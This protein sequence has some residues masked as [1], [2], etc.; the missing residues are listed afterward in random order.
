MIAAAF[1]DASDRY[2]GR[3]AIVDGDRRITYA[4]L[5][6]AA[7]HFRDRLRNEANIGRGD[8]VASLLDNSWQFAAAFFAASSLGAIFVPWNPQW[9]D[10]ES[11]E[12]AGRL[13]LH[14]MILDRGKP[15][16]W[17]P[18]GGH[19][20]S[21]PSEFSKSAVLDCEP[22]SGD[23]TA[24]YL[25]TSGSTG[26]PK[27]VPRSCRNLVDGAANVTSAL[28]MQPGKRL[29]SVV[30]FHHSNG[31]HNCLIAPLLHG[32]T[33]IMQRG[34]TPQGCAALIRK[35]AAN[36][37]IGSPFLF[38]LL[39]DRVS[40]PA[41]M[42]SLDLCISAGARMPEPTVERWLRKT[43]KRI[44]QLYGSTET[45]VITI[46]CDDGAPSHP[47]A[48]V[49]VGKAIPGVEIRLVDGEITVRSPAVMSGYFGEKNEENFHEGFYRTGDSGYVTADGGVYL[50]GR[51]R[52]VI[53]V[54]GVKVDPVEI[55]RVVEEIPGVSACHA[56]SVDGAHGASSIR[57]RLA[58]APEVSVSRDAVVEHCRRRL[59]E[60]KLPRIIEVCDQLPV[61]LSG[62]V[63]KEQ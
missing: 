29:L 23:A 9:R 21:A 1:C 27:I 50:T 39:A 44:R 49:Y 46:D 59:A 11:Q 34:F 28:G 32:A 41:L 62:K 54:A 40:D 30:P 8:V 24:A 16:A 3:I 35:E 55:E 63:R 14:A 10:R 58:L 61:T 37:M 7:A 31:F 38:G 51:L 48:G 6:R 22:L 2:P 42:S 36:V 52:R 13:G 4:E 26:I 20:L 57:V 25:T 15:A 12:L 19:L 47:D 56:D 18:E 5:L 17:K 43:G 53:N 45:S 33:V 60:Y